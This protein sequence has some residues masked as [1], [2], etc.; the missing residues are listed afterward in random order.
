VPRSHMRRDSACALD[1]AQSA[2]SGNLS[3]SGGTASLGQ[4]LVLIAGRWR[5]RVSDLD[6]AA[7]GAPL[8]EASPR[9]SGMLLWVM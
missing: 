6:T 4:A 3:A 5:V 8:L 2:Q 7:P 1:K 9:Q